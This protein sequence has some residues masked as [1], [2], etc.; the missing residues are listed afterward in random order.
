MSMNDVG[1]DRMEWS[2]GVIRTKILL[3]KNNNTWYWMKE[4]VMED[5]FEDEHRQVVSMAVR[6]E[7]N[8]ELRKATNGT[9][10]IFLTVSK[11]FLE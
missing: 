10:Q 8:I 7:S 11:D 3:D 6:D 9:E 1:D 4:N 5:H 2:T